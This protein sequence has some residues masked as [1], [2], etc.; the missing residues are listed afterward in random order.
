ML[1]LVMIIIVALGVTLSFW[2]D[3]VHWFK[4]W[5]S[6]ERARA[7][8]LASRPKVRA[9]LLS[10]NIGSRADDY[11][12]EIDAPLIGMPY[13][14][15]PDID[16]PKPASMGA[17]ANQYRPGDPLVIRD[18]ADLAR[19]LAA[20]QK[21]D[22]KPWLSANKV[23]AATGGDRGPVLEIVREVRGK[24][25]APPPLTDPLRVRDSSGERFI[26]RA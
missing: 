20:L 8:E 24:D 10:I 6:R 14:Y 4:R 25:D 15:R 18:E 9:P 12:D 13:Q 5:W 3:I 17:V 19:T 2:L 7:L 16:Q 21:P 22:G 1:A 11:D 23:Y 26:S